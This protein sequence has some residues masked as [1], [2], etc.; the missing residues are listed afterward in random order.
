M[1]ISSIAG[2]MGNAGQSNYAASKAGLIGF[3]K[4]IAKELAKRNITCN[5]VA[6]GF[7]T[8]EMTDVLPDRVKETVKPLIPMNR[9]GKPEDIA[10]AVNYL[11]GPGAA[12][13][14]GLV[15]VVDGGLCM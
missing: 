14:T 11:V 8:T 6:P 2:V 13:V 12:Y 7:I 1:N 3:T 15:L 4:S 5:A 9:F 10:E